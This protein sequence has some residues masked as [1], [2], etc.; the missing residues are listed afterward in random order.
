VTPE[1]V[2][3]AAGLA[4][5]CGL[6][7]LLAWVLGW[8]PL[9]IAT[10][11]FAG[12]RRWFSAR[13]TVPLAGC[14]AGAVTLAWSGWPVAGLVAGIAASILVSVLRSTRGP[15]VTTKIEAV[16][17]WTELVRD[18]LAASAGLAQ[19]IVAS[20]PVAP[21]PLRIQVGHLA[22][23]VSSGVQI[24]D[25]LRAFA[26]EVAD[27]SADLVVCALVLATE[28]RAQR[29]AD[30]LSALADSIRDEVAMRLRVEASRTASRSSVRTIVLFSL[31]FVVALAVVARSYLEPFR[32]LPGQLALVGI[33][34]MYATGIGLMAHMVRA[35]EAP[36]LIGSEADR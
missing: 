19:A 5:G 9:D 18:T 28:A 22:D 25:A 26:D 36:R 35:R 4:L 34:A 29:L 7:G 6:A 17:T 14:A 11:A 32:T 27:P 10:G 24:A 13:G 31:G 30:L 3:L 23:R 15:D 8:Q 20:A 33:A 16:A 12:R 2:V 1:A 21:A